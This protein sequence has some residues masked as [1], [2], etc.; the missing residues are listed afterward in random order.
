MKGPPA[1]LDGA[2]V[3]MWSPLDSRHRRTGSVRHFADG[4]EQADFAAVAVA[5]YA[6]GAPGSWYLFYCDTTWKVQNDTAYDSFE[7]A[8][9]DAEA[10]FLGIAATWEPHNPNA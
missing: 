10:Q 1:T 6:T 9:A 2:A 3:K 4:R 8:K 5:T 7:E